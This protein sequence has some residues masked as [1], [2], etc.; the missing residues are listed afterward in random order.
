MTTFDTSQHSGGPCTKVLSVAGFLD[1]IG[2]FPLGERVYS[3]G[4]EPAFLLREGGNC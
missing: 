2:L 3:E 4:K 1:Q